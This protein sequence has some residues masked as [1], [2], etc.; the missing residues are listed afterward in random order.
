MRKRKK[1]CPVCLDFESKGQW[2]VPC[3]RSYERY[4]KNHPQDNDYLCIEWTVRRL[5]RTM[6]RELARANYLAASWERMCLSYMK[7]LHDKENP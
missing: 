3:Q 1:V 2:C 4:K 7:R 6:D 5:K